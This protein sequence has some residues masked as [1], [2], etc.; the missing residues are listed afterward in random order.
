MGQIS[1]TFQSRDAVKDAMRAL[2]ETLQ[3]DVFGKLET[4]LERISGAQ[5]D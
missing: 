5:K 4:A 3:K 2:Q 1:I